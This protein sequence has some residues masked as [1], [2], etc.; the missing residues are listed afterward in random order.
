[1]STVRFPYGKE[2]LT[3]D[4]STENFLGTLTSALHG[5]TPLLRGE[6]LVRSAMADPIGSPS[7]Y[8]QPIQRR[9]Y[10]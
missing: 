2:Y 7:L 8:G 10:P 6:A 9:P 4:F 1:M 5:Y 3:Y